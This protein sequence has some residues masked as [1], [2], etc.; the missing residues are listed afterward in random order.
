MS[1]GLRTV[2]VGTGGI[3]Q[4]HLAFV[5]RSPRAELVGVCDLSAAAASYAAERFGAAASGTDLAALLASTAPDVVHVLTPATTHSAIAAQCLRAGAHV[6]SE[7]PVTTDLAELEA[8]LAVADEAGRTLTEDHNY[9]YNHGVQRL[10]E[11]VDDGSLGEVVEVDVRMALDVRAGGAF[12][13]TSLPHP[14]HR[15]PAGV[16]HDVLTHLVY[17]AQ[18][19][20]PGPY[21]QVRAAWRNQGGGDLFKYDDLDALAFA[22]RQ[23]ARIRFT[24]STWPQCLSVTVR[25]TA[26]EA[27]TEL[28]QPYVREVLQRSAGKQLSSTVN[29]F[30]NGAS[31]ARSA[32]RN[33]GHKVSRI[34]TPYH[35]LH[36]FLDLTY[37]ALAAGVE[38]PVT[39]RRMI[40]T[41]AFIDRL[42]EPGNA[43]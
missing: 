31:L 35:G 9:L 10:A 38:P 41:T 29:H 15:M 20:V 24:S 18:H 8:L 14:I 23:H 3:S 19:F 6:I 25:G 30:V 34:E 26:G 39:R 40:E 28:F 21:D 37:E 1:L 32:L 12:A 5:A 11:L 13:D 27:E 16:I 42:L 36:R 33:F 43:L 22:G 2:V 4:E 7:K 17:L